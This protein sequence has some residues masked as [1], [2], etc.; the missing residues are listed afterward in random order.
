MNFAVHAILL[1]FG[2]DNAESSLLIPIQDGSV[3]LR[4]ENSLRRA[5]ALKSNSWCWFHLFPHWA[6]DSRA[7]G[8]A[9][10]FAGQVGPGIQHRP[11]MGS[12][13]YPPLLIAQSLGE[14][15]HATSNVEIELDRGTSY[16]GEAAVLRHQGPRSHRG[17]QHRRCST[18]LYT[19]LDA[20]TRAIVLV[21]NFP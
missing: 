11:C 16:P 1:L 6:R 14:N 5:A 4:D 7:P 10:H 21:D 20:L 9:S 15:R 3:L 8:H 19:Q 18:M 13:E 2:C 12:R 17:W